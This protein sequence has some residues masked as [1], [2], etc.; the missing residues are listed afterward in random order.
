MFHL[1]NQ[2]LGDIQAQIESEKDQQDEILNKSVTE[3]LT[4]D[5]TL[6][7]FFQ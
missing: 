6:E 5:K 1:T 7:I 4:K 3:Y 2:K